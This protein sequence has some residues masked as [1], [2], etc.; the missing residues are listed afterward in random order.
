[1]VDEKENAIEKIVQTYNNLDKAA[2]K[3]LLNMFLMANSESI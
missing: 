2:Q 3:Q 1:M